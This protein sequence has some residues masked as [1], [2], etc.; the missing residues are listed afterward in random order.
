MP[1]SSI[2]GPSSTPY[3]PC[4]ITHGDTLPND[5]EQFIQ[6]HDTFINLQKDYIRLTFDLLGDGLIAPVGAA[7]LSDFLR[8]A[9]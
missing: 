2:A 5:V 3:K 6:C 1:H 8:M 4:A 7:A 9:N